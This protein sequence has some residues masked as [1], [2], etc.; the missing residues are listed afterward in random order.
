MRPIS[1]A[2]KPPGARGR[3]GD[4]RSS[5]SSERSSRRSKVARPRQTAIIIAIGTP[6]KMT[7][8]PR[9]L[10]SATVSTQK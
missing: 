3:Y 8:R 4:G 1:R 6:A 5:S 7:I 2:K 9:P 10:D